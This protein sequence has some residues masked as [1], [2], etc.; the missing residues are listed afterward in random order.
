MFA[1]QVE[2]A[3][4]AAEESKIEFLGMVSRPV[5][6]QLVIPPC[7][8]PRFQ[9]GGGPRI[10]SDEIFL[11]KI[12]IVPRRGP[13]PPSLDSSVQG[14]PETSE[15]P[16][17]V[18]DSPPPQ[19]EDYSRGMPSYPAPG[20]RPY[21]YMRKVDERPWRVFFYDADTPLYFRLG[22]R[23]HREWRG[24]QRFHLRIDPESGHVRCI[25][26]YPKL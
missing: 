17:A 22:A 15:P 3:Q 8:P 2:K 13:S 19:D 5:R 9:V 21:K 26:S 14:R 24:N 23:R 10:I 11:G 1:R 25:S 18:K 16:S 20:Y 12:K 7:R 4:R 6:P